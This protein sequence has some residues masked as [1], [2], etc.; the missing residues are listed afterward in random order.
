[1]TNPLQ[2]IIQKSPTLSALNLFQHRSILDLENNFTKTFVLSPLNKK[3]IAAITLAVCIN[4]KNHNLLYLLKDNHVL[5]HLEINE[6]NEIIA[7]VATMNMNNNLYSFKH[8]IQNK[9]YEDMPSGLNMSQF[10]N[11]I[12]GKNLME[13][14]ALVVSNLNHCTACT[15]HHEEK[16][17]KLGIQSET[18]YQSIQLSSFLKNL[19]VF[20]FLKV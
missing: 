8:N 12:I 7:I 14:I 15:Q 5:P 20:D 19:C 17:L 6:Q 2:H 16:C 18:V 1:M 13:I 11:P 4:Q 3:I 9:T 10:V